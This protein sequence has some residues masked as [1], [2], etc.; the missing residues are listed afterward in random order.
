M[1][2][3]PLWVTTM[4]GWT[5]QDTLVLWV[6]ITLVALVLASRNLMSYRTAGHVSLWWAVGSGIY[7]IFKFLIL[8]KFMH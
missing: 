3:Q 8:M 6:V 1:K 2:Q 4:S 5:D 7:T